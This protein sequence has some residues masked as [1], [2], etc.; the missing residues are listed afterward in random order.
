MRSLRVRPITYDCRRPKFDVDA[1]PP[2]QQEIPILASSCV[3][4]VN[5]QNN[6]QALPTQAQRSALTNFAICLL[7]V[8]LLS[9]SITSLRLFADVSFM[10]F[11]VP[12]ILPFM[13]GYTNFVYDGAIFI[14]RCFQIYHPIQH[15]G[16]RT[17]S[18]RGYFQNTT[19]CRSAQVIQRTC[20]N[21]LV[22]RDDWKS[23]QSRSSCTLLKPRL[24]NNAFHPG[25]VGLRQ[26]SLLPHTSGRSCQCWSI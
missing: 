5:S 10:C 18:T 15:G 14:K 17:I 20:V 6:G 3:P 19:V 7:L 12:T 8:P 1:N 25:G 16:E 13:Q 24:L 9:S 4:A 11:E 22:L 26:A 21:K 23:S 2:W